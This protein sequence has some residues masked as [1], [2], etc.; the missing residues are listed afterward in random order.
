MHYSS[1]M[2]W[3]ALLCTY[4]PPPHPGPISSTELVTP[5]RITG[6]RSG[7]WM[8]GEGGAGSEVQGVRQ[9]RGVSKVHGE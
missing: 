3:H 8:R 7:A 1:Y 6:C 4:V 2:Q 9:V 5:G